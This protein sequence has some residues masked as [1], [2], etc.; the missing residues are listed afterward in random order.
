MKNRKL[1]FISALFFAIILISSIFVFAMGS[2]IFNK[3]KDNENYQ[4][5]S[6]KISCQNE[7]DC[8]DDNLC[9]IDYCSE[10]KCYNT[11]VVLCYQ[12]DGCCPESCTPENDNDC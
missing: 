2:I 11:K 6:E 4:N 5:K 12:N 8:N 3:E 1:F 9:T 7:L 10:E